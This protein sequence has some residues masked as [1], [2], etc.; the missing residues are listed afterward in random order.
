MKLKRLNFPKMQI[1]LT[2]D[3]GYQAK[4]LRTLAMMMKSYGDV[5]V[6]GPKIHQSGMGMAV[7]LGLKQLAYKDLGISEGVHWS[8]LNAT[9]ASCAKYGINFMNPGPDIL[10]SGINHGSNATTGALYSGTL[11]ACQEAVLCGIPAI[12]VSI[13]DISPDADFSAVEEFFPEVFSRLMAAGPAKF[14]TYYNVNFPALPADQIKGIRVTHMGLGKWIREFE[15][16]NPDKFRHV[17]ITAESLGRSSKPTNEEGE[18]LYMMTGQYID[19]LD[20]TPGADHRTMKEGYITI[21]AHT[22]LNTDLDELARLRQQGLESDF[23]K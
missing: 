7:D 23:Q 5:T 18:K 17:G 22:I 21:T 4:G 3:D 11:G 1:L 15:D 14:G 8:Y 19:L 16:W 9:P 6:V 13:D 10:I 20:N 2:N 12:G